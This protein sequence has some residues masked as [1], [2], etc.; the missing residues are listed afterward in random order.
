MVVIASQGATETTGLTMTLEI[1]TAQAI[2]DRL[3][4]SPLIWFSNPGSGDAIKPVTAA[5][6]SYEEAAAWAA[7]HPGQFVHFP[8]GDQMGAREALAD[9]LAVFT[10]RCTKALAAQSAAA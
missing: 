10:R 9:G 8:G 2:A 6:L 3:M 5:F 4:F 1:T 7:R